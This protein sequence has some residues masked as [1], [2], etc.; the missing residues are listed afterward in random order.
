MNQS[1][2]NHGG[3][4]ITDCCSLGLIRPHRHM[5]TTCPTCGGLVLDLVIAGDS[6]EPA[7]ARD[8]GI[9]VLAHHQRQHRRT[10]AEEHA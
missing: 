1:P 3:D 4:V 9:R 5:R 6:P 8:H 7:A 2:P 10:T